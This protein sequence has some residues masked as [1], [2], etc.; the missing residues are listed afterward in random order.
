MKGEEVNT[1]IETYLLAQRFYFL[2]EQCRNLIQ[3]S[4][5]PVLK[6]YDLNHSQHLVLLILW[7]A[8]LSKNEIISTEI[9]YLLGLEK[10]SVSTIIEN[11]HKRR[12]IERKRNPDDRRAIDLNLTDTG[13]ELLRAHLPKTMSRISFES[14]F[15]SKDYRFIF[16]FLE[17]LRSYLA[18]ENN[19][20][21]AV[22]SEAFK[23]LLLD[24]Q[25]QFREI[26][27]AERNNA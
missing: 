5:Q 22:Y 3:K 10:H 13:R 12:L 23:K 6:E 16:S 1:T 7:Y 26:Y 27:G 18:E 25:N 19:R 17:S 4:M 2:A 20:S 9:A 21:P 11:L 14:E 8:E 15:T 24:G